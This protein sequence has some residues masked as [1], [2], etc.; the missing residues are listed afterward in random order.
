MGVGEGGGEGSGWEPRVCASVYVC[1]GACGYVCVC[2]CVCMRV[3][4]C[5]CVCMSLWQCF[6]MA[7]VK[8]EPKQRNSGQVWPSLIVIL[9]VSRVGWEGGGG[10]DELI[11]STTP[12]LH[13]VG[14]QRLSQPTAID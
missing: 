3:G 2:V 8:S 9:I 12:C 7:T 6:K 4:L 5:L 11:L 10:D 14:R 1:S 13:S